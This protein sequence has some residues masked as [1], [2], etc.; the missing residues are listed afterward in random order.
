V[1]Q[2]IGANFV[3]VGREVVVGMFPLLLVLAELISV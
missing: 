3:L 2:D 1:V